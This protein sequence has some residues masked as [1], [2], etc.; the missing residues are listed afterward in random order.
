MA[1]GHVLRLSFRSADLPAMR[2]VVLA[3]ILLSACA[4]PQERARPLR[5]RA[6][7]AALLGAWCNSD[8]GGR[9]CWAYD[10]FFDDGT[11]RACGRQPDEREP[12][13]GLGAVSIQG[14][15]MCYVVRRATPNFWVRA[16]SRYCTRIVEISAS[17]HVYEDIDSGTRH[18]LHRVPIPSVH[19]PSGGP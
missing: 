3:M 7:S 5:D 19:C 13:D 9:S 10:Q 12:F 16:G 17:T 2:A 18:T 11:L 15:V 1:V 6:L 4:G 8:D 14:D